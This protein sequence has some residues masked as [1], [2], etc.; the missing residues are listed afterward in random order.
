MRCVNWVGS[1]SV[2]VGCSGSCCVCDGGRAHVATGGLVGMGGCMGIGGEKNDGFPHTDLSTAE[3]NG[4]APAFCCAR[5]LSSTAFSLAVFPRDFAHNAPK[6]FRSSP[7]PRLGNPTADPPSPPSPSASSHS[8]LS[9]LRRSWASFATVSRRA[10][11]S[12]RVVASGSRLLARPAK[13]IPI[14]AWRV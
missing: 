9:S 14:M 5:F 2:V 3:P 4:L 1:S 8:S 7:P 13:A 10:A 12:A 6:S 11:C